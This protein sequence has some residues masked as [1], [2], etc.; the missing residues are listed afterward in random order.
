M[1]ETIIGNKRNILAADSLLATL[2]HSELSGSLYIG[3]PIL[4]ALDERITI[5][6]LLICREHGI[7]VFD[8]P[9]FGDAPPPRAQIE[10]RQDDLYLAVESLLKRVRDLVLRR[11]LRVKISTI[12][13]LATA[14]PQE[15]DHPLIVT[16]DTLAGYLESLAPISAEELRLANSALERVSTIRAARKRQPT[17]R[18]DSRGGVMAQIDLEIA[19][20]DRW[21]KH[22]AIAIPDGPQ[23][24][25]GL[26]GSGKT[27]VLALKAAYLHALNPDWNI[28]L[29]FQTRSLHQQLRALV[30]RFSF[31]HSNDEPD[32]S[33]LQIINAWGSNRQPG[34]Y[35][36]IA[37][38]FDQTP[39]DFLYAKSQYG[40]E[41][42]FQ[43]VC[44]E[45]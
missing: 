7:V 25:R 37:E 14:V 15:G 22:A 35:A 34:I 45:H 2:A 27:I 19:N 8:F 21:Q 43:G 5:D 3:Y 12:S 23:R 36:Q 40:S 10:K 44:D 28:A 20:L 38:H 39:R 16:P 11:Q 1:L 9:D 26:A 41:K 4:P 13:Y 32:W 42:S 17:Q 33:K 18:H 29:T 31:E 24:I 6:A 30:R